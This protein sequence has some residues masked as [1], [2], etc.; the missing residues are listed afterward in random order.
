MIAHASFDSRH[1]LRF[2]RLISPCSAEP[3]YHFEE[4]YFGKPLHPIS[5]DKPISCTAKWEVQG[6]YDERISQKANWNQYVQIDASRLDAPT[7]WK[8]VLHGQIADVTVAGGAYRTIDTETWDVVSKTETDLVLVHK[9]P[10]RSIST[11]TIDAKN[12]T[13]VHCFIGRP[14][15]A[16]QGTVFWGVCSNE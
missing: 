10:Q 13:F 1:S 14:L 12:G 5:F 8:I 7:L 11:M 15:D 16:N 2:G 4:A 6:G 3:K 9:D